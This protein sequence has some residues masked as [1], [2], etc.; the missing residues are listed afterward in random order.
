MANSYSGGGT[1]GTLVAGG[2]D[3]PGHLL[4]TQQKI[5]RMA[6]EPPGYCLGD[7][8]G[9]SVHGTRAKNSQTLT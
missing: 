1:D 9:Q 8:S 7:A 3:R 6:D 2:E 4:K 5:A